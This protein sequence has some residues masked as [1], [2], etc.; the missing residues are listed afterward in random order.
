MGGDGENR[1]GRIQDFG[2]GGPG[3]RV[4]KRGI[5]AHTRATF[6]S[7]L[8]EVWGSPKSVCGGGKGGGGIHPWIHPCEPLFLKKSQGSHLGDIRRT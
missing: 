4:L 5:F 2:K 7:P 1:Q 3:N 8:Y 6:F